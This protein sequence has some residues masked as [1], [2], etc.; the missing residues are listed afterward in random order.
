MTRRRPATRPREHLA[1]RIGSRGQGRLKGDHGLRGNQGKVGLVVGYWAANVNGLKWVVC[2]F[3]VIWV[4]EVYTR[5]TQ[6]K[7]GFLEVLPE[8][9]FGY[10]GFG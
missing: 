3:R 7:F 10:F 4:Q 8:I 2:L 9:E 1:E 5:I 6:N